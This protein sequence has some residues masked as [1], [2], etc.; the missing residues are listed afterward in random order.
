MGA[1]GMGET[2]AFLLLDEYGA[3]DGLLAPPWYMPG[4]PMGGACILFCDPLCEVFV[5]FVALDLAN[6]F[7][8]GLPNWFL[9]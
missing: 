6:W 7:P 3:G 2:P 1:P 4:F 5:V 9:T 8:N